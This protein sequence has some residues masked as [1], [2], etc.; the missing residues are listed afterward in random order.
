MLATFPGNSV[1]LFTVEMMGDFTSLREAVA[2]LHW[3]KN[4]WN[5]VPLSDHSLWDFDPRE[6]KTSIKQTNKNI[7]CI[8][9]PHRV[10]LFQVE[11][12]RKKTY[13]ISLTF[14]SEKLFLKTE[15]KLLM[16]SQENFVK[17]WFSGCILKTV[18]IL[19]MQTVIPMR[20]IQVNFRRESF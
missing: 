18:Q 20:N 5:N 4:L 6:S 3:N 12:G 8:Y 13:W 14:C 19:Q 16:W 1:F 10:R 11:K 15:W 7:P 9:L 2:L 17:L